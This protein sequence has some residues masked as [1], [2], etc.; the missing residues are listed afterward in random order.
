MI[1]IIDIPRIIF[2][3]SIIVFIVILFTFSKQV[4]ISFDLNYFLIYMCIL[5]Y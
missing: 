3:C 5:D 1:M 4:N 2:V